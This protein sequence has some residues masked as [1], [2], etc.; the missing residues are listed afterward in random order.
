MCRKSA[1]A[2]SSMRSTSPSEKKAGGA[3]KN[4]ERGRIEEPD[5]NARN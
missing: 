5:I 1:S 3:G 4:D 2:P